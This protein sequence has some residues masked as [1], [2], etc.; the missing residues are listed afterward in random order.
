MFAPYNILVYCAVL[1]Y[2]LLRSKFLLIS[3]KCKDL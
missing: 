3:N 1:K 2:I